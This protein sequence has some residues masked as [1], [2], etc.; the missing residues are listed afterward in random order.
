L[1]NWKT[2]KLHLFTSA[3]CC[4]AKNK[5]CENYHHSFMKRSNEQSIQPTICTQS[6][7]RNGAEKQKK[8][9]GETEWTAIEERKRK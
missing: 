3:L 5:E 6:A 1:Q 7:E 2:W 8:A 9:N 4:F